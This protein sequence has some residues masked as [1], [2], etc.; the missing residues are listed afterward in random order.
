MDHIISA[1]ICST[2]CETNLTIQHLKFSPLPLESMLQTVRHGGWE[3]IEV[4][5]AIFAFA[6]G[7]Q[8]G[9]LLNFVFDSKFVEGLNP[10]QA[11]W[12]SSLALRMGF[13]F[14]STLLP[15][16]SWTPLQT[17]SRHPTTF[18]LGRYAGIWNWVPFFVWHYYHQPAQ[19]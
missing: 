8:C 14:H 12:H 18:N 19:N 7:V 2:L 10:N 1:M 16:T 3:N 17:A 9:S 6:Q 15:S 5:A 13:P 11:V 4:I